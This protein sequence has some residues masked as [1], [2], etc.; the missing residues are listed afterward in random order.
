[1]KACSLAELQECL[2]VCKSAAKRIVGQAVPQ[3]NTGKPDIQNRL[4]SENRNGLG[5]LPDS[6]LIQDLRTIDFLTK[7][8]GKLKEYGEPVRRE[9]EEICYSIIRQLREQIAGKAR[10][11]PRRP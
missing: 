4:L 10:L 8:A 5:K 2:E 11:K 9:C 3:L 7:D 6:K 1:M